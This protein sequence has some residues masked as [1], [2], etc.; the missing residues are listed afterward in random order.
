MKAT[1]HVYIHVWLIATSA[2]FDPLYD[3]S[4]SSVHVH[5]YNVCCVST[6]H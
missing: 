2:H 1:L 5:V 6:F 3:A 4:H